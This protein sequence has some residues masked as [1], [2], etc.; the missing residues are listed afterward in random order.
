MEEITI[1]TITVYISTDREGYKSVYTDGHMLNGLYGPSFQ[2]LVSAI[3][4]AQ[5]DDDRDRGAKLLGGD[6]PKVNICCGSS[7]HK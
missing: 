7:C 1:G 3:R 2:R 5:S 4:S 6:A